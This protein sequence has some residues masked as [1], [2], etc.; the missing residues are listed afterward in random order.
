MDRLNN[1]PSNSSSGEA[2]RIFSEWSRLKES[3]LVCLTNGS[4]L[5]CM[6]CK[7]DVLRESL[8]ECAY[9]RYQIEQFE[10]NRIGPYK[11]VI[12]LVDLESWETDWHTVESRLVNLIKELRINRDRNIKD[13]PRDNTASVSSSDSSANRNKFGRSSGFK[14][15]SGK[16]LL[17]SEC[18]SDVLNQTLGEC[19]NQI[20]VRNLRFRNR[21]QSHPSQGHSPYPNR[22]SNTQSSPTKPA[23]SLNTNA[24]PVSLSGSGK[25]NRSCLFCNSEDHR[26]VNCRKYITTTSRVNVLTSKNICSRCMRRHNSGVCE[27]A[28]FPCSYCHGNHHR[29]VCDSRGSTTASLQVDPS[30]ILPGDPNN[31]EAL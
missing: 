19:E 11:E 10:I 16:E 24:F 8:N 29:W 31:G 28:V 21:S 18:G 5:S 12:A 6:K 17:D 9:Y 22:T 1:N 13:K 20:L 30:D 14:G 23:S 25:Y 15:S 3:A 2:N 7:P 4:K 27:I 26:A